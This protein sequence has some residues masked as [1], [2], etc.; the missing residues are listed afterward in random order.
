MRGKKKS[1]WRQ[2][3]A[4]YFMITKLTYANNFDIMKG[5]M[6]IKH[7]K[8][9]ISIWI[10]TTSC[11]RKKERKRAGEVYNIG[12][13]N[14]AIN[15]LYYYFFLCTG[16]TLNFYSFPYVRDIN[17]TS[18]FFSRLSLSFFL[19]TLLFFWRHF[20]GKKWRRFWMQFV[21]NDLI[22]VFTLTEL[23]LS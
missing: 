5:M 18:N 7:I 17:R 1:W 2:K 10:T 9:K 4:V 13:K 19:F 8:I 22:K 12:S 20:Y 15:L 3:K 23:L 11:G 16:E 21:L 14:I 6:N